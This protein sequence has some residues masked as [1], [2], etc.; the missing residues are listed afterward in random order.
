MIET[1]NVDNLHNSFL[2][3]RM[4]CDAHIV[5]R[6]PNFD[7]FLV[8]TKLFGKRK[9]VGITCH[10]LKNTIGMICFFLKNLL[11]KKLFILKLPA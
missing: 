7:I 8:L 11:T 1:F 2:N 3:L 9:V 4:S 6:T 5:I 10:F